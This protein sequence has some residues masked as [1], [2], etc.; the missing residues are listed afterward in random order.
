MERFVMPDL[1]CPFAPAINEH[2]EAV[3]EGIVQWALS[4]GLLPDERSACTFRAAILTLTKRTREVDLRTE[5]SQEAQGSPRSS[6]RVEVI[7]VPENE[8]KG[9]PIRRKTTTGSPVPDLAWRRGEAQHT[10]HLS[11]PQGLPRL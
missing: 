1:Y 10:I 3:E 11:L 6:N 2:A 7:Y 4:F 8:L 9:P 5:L